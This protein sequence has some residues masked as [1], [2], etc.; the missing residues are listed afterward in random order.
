M[1][2]GKQPLLLLG[3]FENSQAE[4]ERRHQK[5]KPDMKRERIENQESGQVGK[6]H[7]FV[8]RKY[9]G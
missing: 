3:F 6:K 2:A 8:V 1:S 5:K 7:S 4:G 9:P